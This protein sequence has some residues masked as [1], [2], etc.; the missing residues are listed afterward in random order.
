MKAG[1]PPFQELE[2]DVV[3][4]TCPT[5]SKFRLGTDRFDRELLFPESALLNPGFIMSL[6]VYVLCFNASYYFVHD[7]YSVRKGVVLITIGFTGR[8]HANKACHSM[9]LH[10]H[11]LVLVLLTSASKPSLPDSWLSVKGCFLQSGSA[12]YGLS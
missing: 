1:K 9:S 5:F 6:Q 10:C 3:P 7:H 12:Q 2:Q 8:A 4:I 11:K